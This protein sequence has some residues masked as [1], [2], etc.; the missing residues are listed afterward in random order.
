MEFKI[1]E[2]LNLAGNLLNGS[3]LYVAEENLVLSNQI[4]NFLK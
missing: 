2:V 1:I 3:S 4:L